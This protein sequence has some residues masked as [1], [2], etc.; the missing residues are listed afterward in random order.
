MKRAPVRAA[1]APL[2]PVLVLLS[3]GCPA[4]RSAATPLGDPA[5][6][7]RV[8]P[9]ADEALAAAPRTVDGYLAVSAAHAGTTAGHEALYRA[10]SLAFEAKDWARARQAF[11]TLLFENPLH[12]FADDARLKLGLATL[13][14]KAYRDAYQVL[15]NAAARLTGAARE[16][17]L[18]GAEKA[19]ALGGLAGSDALRDAVKALAD[20]PEG[21][22]REAARAKLV[23]TVESAEFLEVARAVEE[24]PLSHPA[25]DTLTFKLARIYYHL[26][27]WG[28]L[29]E[30]L[31]ELLRS[32][33]S[34]PWAADARAL[35][36][37]AEGRNKVKP[38]T[39]GFVLPTTGKYKLFGEAVLRGAQLALKG[40]DVELVVKD[41]QGD[42]QAAGRAVEELVFQDGAVAAL[43]PLMGEESRRAALVAE[44]LQLPI[45]TLSRA[46]GITGIGPHVFRNMLT[47]SAQA[48]ALAEYATKVLGHKS[49]A[50][51][52]PNIPYGVELTN[53]FWDA[54]LAQGG[55]MRGA[56]TYEH[57]Q[58]TFTE[59]A[60]KLVGRYHLEDRS[61]FLEQT[62]EVA[63]QE[64]DAYRKRKALEKVKGKVEPIVDFEALLV[65]DDWKRVGLV[66]PA[67]AVEDII[68]NACD[69]ADLERIRKT[70]GKRDVKDLKTVTLLGT[71]QWSSPRG[72]SGMPE[73][74]ER[75]GKFIQCSIYVDGFYVDS[76]RPA[77]KKFV[78]AYREA[79][80]KDPGLLEAIGHD[81]AKM[82]RQ[83]IESG[84]PQTR[85]AFRSGLAELRDFE[86]ATGSTSFTDKR[87]V[88]KTLFFLGI[89]TKGVK[90]LKPPPAAAS[91]TTAKAPA[92]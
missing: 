46:E 60:R 14:L 66:A 82:A 83:V 34:S 86:G 33:P 65:P 61:D 32:A 6:L 63:E 4:R 13:E 16:Q 77:T 50:V 30:T 15:S 5:S 38:R 23:E 49:F 45:L 22:S 7:V 70:T 1:L 17:A 53:A 79:H 88:K 69:S 52:Y 73:L 75:A 76:E 9:A 36:A 87:E 51:L 84:K 18:E 90:E 48:D 71:N 24:T 59:E 8:D 80:G 39:L 21:P 89:D 91:A 29:H 19:R 68:T 28:R 92:P 74:V 81:V 43:G 12:P 40:S 11:N 10:G 55:T 41:S 35:Q 42:G 2:L 54:V 64:L 78:G 3:L 26:R 62:R 56:E 67:L 27:E 44:E 57:D 85:E 58:T 47:N 20:A 25:W 31:D 72:R 37:R